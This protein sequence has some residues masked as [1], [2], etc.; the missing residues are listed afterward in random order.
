MGNEH[1][2][3]AIGPLAFLENPDAAELFAKIDYQ[4]KDGFHFQDRGNQRPYFFFIEQN[5][6]SLSAYYDKFFGVILSHGGQGMD[7]YY[8]LDFNG[9]DRG[10]IDGDHRYF[11]KAEYVIVGFLIYKII[12]IDRYFDLNSIKKLQATIKTDYE[13]LTK[14]IYRLLAKLRKT[15]PT[16]FGGGKLD[17][18]IED[19]LREFKKL[20]WVVMEED[21]FD[22][23][24]SFQR[25]NK[26][27]SDYINNVEQMIKDAI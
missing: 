19:A 17:D 24:P 26:V 1:K 6:A 22:V 18:V 21:F 9:T 27:Y 10:G 4:L 2:L 8:Y 20:G 12:Y 14:D 25:L 13:E 16:T 5:E 7:R 15:N 23:M 3:S 11:M